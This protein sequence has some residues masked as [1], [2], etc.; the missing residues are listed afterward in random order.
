MRRAFV[1]TLSDL[2]AQ[3]DRIVLLTGDLGFGVLTDYQ[4][5][6]PAQFLNVGVAE[7]N[8]AGVGAGLALTGAIVVT[9]SI[10]NF[11]TNQRSIWPRLSCV[12]SYF[13]VSERQCGFV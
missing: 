11:P 9:Y 10:G 4:E 5:S 8:L 13:L 3:D 2:A 1:E 7:Q 6:F 12:R